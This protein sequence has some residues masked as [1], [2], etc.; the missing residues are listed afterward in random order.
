MEHRGRTL[1][2]TNETYLIHIHIY[3][4]IYIY[5]YTYVEFIRYV[6]NYVYIT[7]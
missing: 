2:Q 1:W 7:E 4:Y 3:I 6:L 5:I